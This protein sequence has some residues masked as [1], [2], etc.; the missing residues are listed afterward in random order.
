MPPCH[1]DMWGQFNKNVQKHSLKII[2]YQQEIHK[3]A[4]FA[5]LCGKFSKSAGLWRDLQVWQHWCLLT[6]LRETFVQ[7]FYLRYWADF[8]TGDVTN[9]GLHAAFFY[10]F[11]S[12]GSRLVTGLVSLL[13]TQPLYTSDT[14][15]ICSHLFSNLLICFLV[16]TRSH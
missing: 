15:K 6:L 12:R 7:A 14:Y 8:F 5:D 11:D 1:L 9:S 3:N 10:F 2:N 4:K 16:T 13:K